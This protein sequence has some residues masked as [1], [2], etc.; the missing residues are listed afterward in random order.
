VIDNLDLGL[1]G[2]GDLD[3]Y[4]LG[5]ECDL[6]VV[7]VDDRGQRKDGTVCIVDD[8]VDGRVPDDVQVTAQVL[9]FLLNVSRA[10]VAG[11]RDNYVPRRTPSAAW[12]SS[13][14]SGSEERTQSA[15]AR[16]LRMRRD[17]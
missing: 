8:G 9:V 11:L 17:P 4:V 16:E 14:W 5:V 15:P 1:V 13:S 7:A 10:C 3:Q 2:R 6:A 12:H